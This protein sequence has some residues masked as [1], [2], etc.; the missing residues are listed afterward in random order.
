MKMKNIVVVEAISTGY[1][2]V[3][4]IVRRGY[5]PVVLDT[6]KEGPSGLDKVIEEDRR[7][8]YHQ[9]L[10]LKEADTYEET[11]QM[12]RELRPVLIVAGSE[13][14]VILATRLS[15]DLGLPGNPTGSLDAM[16]KKDA[17]HEAVHAAGLRSIR[18]KNVVS[19]EEALAFCREKGFECAVVKP[20]QSA[21]S[22][23]LFLCDN[24][25]E[26]EEAVRS[27]LA[28]RDLFG[29]PIQKVLVQERIFGTEYIVNTVSCAGAHRLNSV[30][31]YRKEKTPER[32]YIYDYIEFVD[33]LESGHNELIEYALNVADAIGFQNGIIHGEYMV[34]E[35]GPVLIEVNCRPMGCSMPGEYL[36]LILGQHET[37]AALDSM[38][39]P[40]K[41][42]KDAARP[43]RLLRKAYLKIIIVP[44]AIEAEDHP[45]WQ[46][47]AQL[48]S[49]YHISANDPETVAQYV[50]TRDLE[51]NGGI[52]YLVHDDKQVVEEDLQILRRMEQSFFKLML[53][54]GM[55][56]RWFLD[57]RIPRPDFPALLRECGARGAVLVAADEP[58]EIPGTQCV[59]AES[60][61]DAHKGFDYVV[62][63]YQKT[64]LSLK[65]SACL[66]LLFD[67]MELA[68]QGGKV[69]IP[70]TTYRYLSYGREGAEELMLVKGLTVE[71]PA[72]GSIERVTGTN[73]R[74]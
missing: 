71:A 35:K 10:F 1:N 27:L 61:S 6:R 67:T 3:E 29:R 25:A 31:R 39:D 33:R 47:A 28:M 52:I 36:D 43:Y 44:E 14:G 53:N 2:Y 74:A 11:L 26:V 42:R 73:E 64:I 5:R 16:T 54:D 45:I 4:D 30:L 56:R 32:G 19:P 23:G 22:Q 70:G 9:P 68:R 40:V 72:A 51:S 57:E 7:K 20:L 21:G 15:E 59:T 63:G 24:L 18:G 60:L 13:A 55:S 65:E 49:T 66:K 50:R 69:I 34:D 62:I 37:D 41:F 58:Q 48:R 46:V 8:F 38:L 17:M 12:V